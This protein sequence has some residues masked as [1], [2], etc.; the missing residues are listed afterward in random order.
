VID[1]FLSMLNRKWPRSEGKLTA[2]TSTAA[3]II[4]THFDEDAVNSWSPIGRWLHI[5]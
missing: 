4:K 1:E 5:E 3:V 2:A